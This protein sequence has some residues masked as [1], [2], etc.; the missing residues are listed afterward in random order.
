MAVDIEGSPQLPAPEDAESPDDASGR[1]PTLA[2]RM[3]EMMILAVACVLCFQVQSHFFGSIPLSDDLHH[4]ALVCRLHSGDI[5]WFEY[6]MT[7]YREHFLPV[8]RAWYYITWSE[9]GVDPWLWHVGITTVHAFS[10]VCLFYIL[11]RYLGNL[12][13][14]ATGTLLWAV[15]SFGRMDNTLNWIAASHFT[16]GVAWML[17]ASACLTRF[18]SKRSLVWAA[19]MCVCLL[20]SIGSMGSMIILAPLLPLQY[21][22]LERREDVDSVQFRAW[23]TAWGIPV[24]SLMLVQPALA[25]SSWSWT[26]GKVSE[27]SLFGSFRRASASMLNALGDLLP[28]WQLPSSLYDRRSLEQMTITAMACG[29]IA[30]SLWFWDR[31]NV[32]L[33]ATFALPI[34]LF[35]G[36][37]HL[38]RT[39]VAQVMVSTRYDYLPTLIWCIVIAS[40]ADSVLRFLPEKLPR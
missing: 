20:T 5:S 15:C 6:I 36:L 22:L 18:H 38:S 9:V 19:G 35:V 32:R 16:F 17:A 7:P 23:L 13:A 3:A 40:L 33:I 10:A 29:L 4:L 25:G 31:L 11:R 28:I 14:A 37:I 21:W 27:L 2:V 8:W 39:N 30:A 34:G 24:V 26:F 12:V 1:K